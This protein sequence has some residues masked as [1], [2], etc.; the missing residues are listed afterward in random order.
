IYPGSTQ[1]EL[2]G[3]EFGLTTIP[4]LGLGTVLESPPDETTR[5][6][7]RLLTVYIADNWGPDS[8]DFNTSLRLRA[9]TLGYDMFFSNST[10]AE[11]TYIHDEILA[12][13][14]FMLTNQAYEVWPFRPYLSNRSTMIAASLGLAAIC[15]DGEADPLFL[16]AALNQSGLLISRWLNYQC[17][18]DG[19][20]NEGVTYATWSLTH[21][22]YYFWARLR[23]DGVDY[24]ADQKIR[25][26]ENWLAYELLPEG[27]GY[28]NNIQDCSY[29]GLPMSKHTTYFDWAQTM[30]GSG[31][32]AYIWEHAAGVYGHDS[33][34][35]ADK[36]ATVI[37]NQNL[38]YEQPDSVLPPSMLWA[39]RGLYYYRSGWPSGQS[40]GDVLFSYYC[41]EFQGGHAQEDQGQFTLYGY[42]GTWVM[43]H[44]PG[45]DAAKSQ[46]HN[47]VLI[48]GYGQHRAG[49]SIGT[50]GHIR[51]YLLSGYADYIR[52]DQTDAYTTHSPLNNR[53]FPF[54]YSDWSWGLG[55]ANPVEHAI[56]TVIAVRDP[57]TPPYFIIM[58]DIDKDGL[59]HMYQWRL[60]TSRNNTIDTTS[61]PIRIARGG[62][63]MDIH[64]LEPS[65]A[66]LQK[67]ITYFNNRV[68][69]PDSNVLGLSDSAVNA[70]FSVVLVPGDAT[71][72]PPTVRR[73]PE[74]WG[75][76]ITVAW[77]GGQTDVLMINDS[78]E[79]ISHIIDMQAGGL[80]CT[81]GPETPERAP[82]TSV[83]VGTDASLALLRFDGVDLA[84]Y[85][86][87]DATRFNAGGIDRVTIDNG[88][89]T[90]GFSGTTFDINRYDADFALYGPGVTDVFY[91]KQR[92][93]VVE[94]DGFLTRDPVTGVPAIV[95]APPLDVRAFPNP[96]NPSTTLA[97]ELDAPAGVTV[98]V[99]DA[100]GRLVKRL[101]KGPL[102]AGAH[103]LEWNG[104]NETGQPVA[105]GVYFAVI[106]A[107]HHTRTI[108]LAFIK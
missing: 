3:D 2:L 19:A 62:A 68:P 84:R 66:S 108:K 20:Y 88:P 106:T 99:F 56:R 94:R 15:L 76:T 58:D 57:G 72:T 78:G 77:A 95:P 51:S 41:G 63:F 104:S 81:S 86:L 33:G 71:V 36:A 49:A 69:D 25:R 22:I 87:V 37:F 55:G 24:S 92:I 59:P 61:N 14:D 70:R 35:D 48:D 42:G 11:R 50:D 1:Q 52:G 67:T 101:W 38:A 17:G 74:P 46:A 73:T 7:G 13:V 65:L 4:N 40:S 82:R 79:M 60:H 45:V 27:D 10:D 107:G 89:V 53:G 30:W 98:A 29:L 6:M 91:R 103:R 85:M 80:S 105:S 44:G 12:Y 100:A 21:L 83:A 28:A 75:S 93:H 26:M 9:L 18:P 43:D 102:T 8:D 90:I 31:L 5:E 97:I 64:V 54:P 16:D 32:C 34:T 23:Y 39:H 96:F 47:I